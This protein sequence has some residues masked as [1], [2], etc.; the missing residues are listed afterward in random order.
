MLADLGWVDFDLSVP[1]ILPSCFCQIPISPSR[2]G[3]TVEH[4]KFKSTKPSISSHGT[5]CTI[6]PPMGN[7]SSASLM[8][9]MPLEVIV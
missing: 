5:P 3:Q 7:H 4:P 2:V 1:P 6:L 8:S 9:S